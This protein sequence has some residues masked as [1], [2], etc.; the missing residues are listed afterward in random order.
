MAIRSELSSCFFLFF[1]ILQAKPQGKDYLK[2]SSKASKDNKT[3]ARTSI[4]TEYTNTIAANADFSTT[5]VLLL[6]DKLESVHRT[7]LFRKCVVKAN[8]RFG[9]DK[10]TTVK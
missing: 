2:Q 4:N 8:L 10:S 9:E 3:A 6:S 1:C 7:S 5:V